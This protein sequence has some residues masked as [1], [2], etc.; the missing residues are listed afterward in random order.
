MATTTTDDGVEI[1]YDVT[2]AGPTLVLV[3]GITES[4]RAWDPLVTPL[5]EQHTVVAVDVRGHGE[6]GTAA[7]YDAAA[8]AGDAAAVVGALGLD[9]PIVIGHSMGGIVATAY[10]GRRRCRGVMNVDQSINLADFQA[11]VLGAEPML[12]SDAFGDVIA[13]LFD[14]MSGPLP[15]EEVARIGALRRPE[16]GVVLGVW[17]P[18]L[19]LEP[20][21]LGELVTV[22]AGVVRV[23][24][25]AIHGID[26]GPDYGRWLGHAIPGARLEVWE[27][28]GHYPHLVHQERFLERVAVFERSLA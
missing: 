26:P 7:T 6:S 18:L 5:A 27:D 24:Y 19:E 3:H 12:R 17:A 16:Q 15:A 2:G 11:L 1:A 13:A 28:S 25:L 23:P 9:P 10:A 20:T 4:R 21:E 14:S 8:M 22:L